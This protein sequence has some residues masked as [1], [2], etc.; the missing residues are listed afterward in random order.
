MPDTIIHRGGVIVIDGAPFGVPGLEIIDR[1][2][3]GAN[4]TVFEAR[5]DLL[6]RSV[7]VKVWN[8]RGRS[9]AQFEARKIAAL[10]SP[11]L[12]SVYQFGSLGEHP[13]AVMELV[14]DASGKEWLKRNPPLDERL[15]VWRTYS[16][17]LRYLHAQQIEHGDPHLGNLLIFDDPGGVFEF[18]GSRKQTS[19]AA[20]L[21]DIGTSQLWADASRFA[22]REAALILETAQKMFAAYKFA[23]IAP[24]IPKQ[25]YSEVLAMCDQVIECYPV[26]YDPYGGDFQAVRASRL[27][28]VILDTPVF[29]LLAFFALMKSGDTLNPERVARRINAT[30]QHK[31]DIMEADDVITEE[32]CRLYLER[33]LALQQL[34]R[35][36]IIT[37]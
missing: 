29:D 34:R 9:K 32:S 19:V 4:G 7:A 1:I 24:G 33:G 14:R 6:D 21:V 5:D 27:A 11:L 23:E 8:A 3:Q 13:Y 31:S 16:Q 36:R 17:A 2:G 30:L 15:D 10:K 35:G 37:F 28:D 26:L 25:P 22:A 18:T 12:V 20:K